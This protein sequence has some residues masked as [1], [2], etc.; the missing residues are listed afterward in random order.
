MQEIGDGKNN[1]KIY[2]LSSLFFTLYNDY[3]FIGLAPIP[4]SKNLDFFVC[5]EAN[6]L[7]RFLVGDVGVLR[8]IILNVI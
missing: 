5:V 3:L 1:K 8:Q 2:Y 4:E 7:Q 6:P